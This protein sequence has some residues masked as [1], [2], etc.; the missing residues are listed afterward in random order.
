MH[1][2]TYT[3]HP[4]LEIVCNKVII[5]I[6]LVYHG[7]RDAILSHLVTMHQAPGASCIILVLS[8]VLFMQSLYMPFLTCEFF[9]ILVK[10]PCECITANIARGC[11]REPIKHEAQPNAL[12]SRDHVPS[13]IF[14][15][16]HDRERY[17]NWFIVAA[18]LASAALNDSKWALRS[19]MLG[20]SRGR[21]GEPL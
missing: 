16:M 12:F 17:F 8:L 3:V 21:T 7:F 18:F 4:G 11:G 5:I 19:T 13:A 9:N 2:N 14:S 1:H 10:V 6:G 15:V 20:R